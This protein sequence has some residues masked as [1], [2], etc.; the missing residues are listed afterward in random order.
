V[1]KSAATPRL[2]Y[3]LKGLVTVVVAA[4]ILCALARW[5]SVTM[6]LF[7]ASSMC[8]NLALRRVLKDTVWVGM[9]GGAFGA[10]AFRLLSV[11]LSESIVSALIDVYWM[12]Q[13]GAVV[14]AL[15]DVWRNEP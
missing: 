2:Q 14:G 8:G 11:P 1:G 10:V 15:Y 12:G 13:A 9:I 4:S 7:I 3:S 6:S 5:F